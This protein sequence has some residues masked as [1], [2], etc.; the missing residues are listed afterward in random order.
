MYLCVSVCVYMYINKYVCVRAFVC[1]CVCVSVVDH[2]HCCQCVLCVCVF[3]VGGGR[4]RA[5]SPDWFQ[6]PL[7]PTNLTPICPKDL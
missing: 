7:A 4:D 5:C 1:V 2:D 6:G 3:V